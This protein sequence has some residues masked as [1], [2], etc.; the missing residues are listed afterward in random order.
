MRCR[1]ES[2]DTVYVLKTPK[3]IPSD[4]EIEGCSPVQVALTDESLNIT[5][6]SWLLDD[7]EISTENSVSPSISA[8][9][10]HL[11]AVNCDQSKTTV[12]TPVILTLRLK[13][14]QVSQ[15]RY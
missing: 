3:A 13:T 1:I 9:G 8:P 14:T 11:L 6:R 4:K 12:P 15:S 5:S 10:S 7:V 2:S